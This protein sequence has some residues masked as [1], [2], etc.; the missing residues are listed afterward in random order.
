MLCSP[1]DFVSKRIIVKHFHLNERCHQCWPFM[2]HQG[3]DLTLHIKPNKALESKS[4]LE[5]YRSVNSLPKKQMGA[6]EMPGIL[7]IFTLDYQ[8][9]PNPECSPAFYPIMMIIPHLNCSP[10]QTT[11]FMQTVKYREKICSS[12]KLCFTAT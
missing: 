9:Q 10:A 1:Q 2:A 11:D 6:W 5:M 7:T 8:C 4:S 3:F 12:G